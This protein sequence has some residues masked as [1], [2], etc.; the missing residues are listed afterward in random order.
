MS[1]FVVE[2]SSLDSSLS[3]PLPDEFPTREAAIA[4]LSAAT[5]AGTLTL[6]GEVFIADL[7]GAVPVLVMQAP[8]PATAT[9]KMADGVEESDS[10]TAEPDVAEE[11]VGN[12]DAPAADTAYASWEPLAE[13]EDG[14]ALLAEAL[15]RATTSLEDE[16]IVAPSSIELVP[17]ADET[18]EPE[19]SGGADED[20]SAAA[21]EVSE[22]ASV[23]MADGEAVPSTEW[24]W[25]N[26]ESYEVSETATGVSDDVDGESPTP[27]ESGD[28]VRE[29]AESAEPEGQDEDVVESAAEAGEPS[30]AAPDDGDELAEVL[31]DLGTSFDEPAAEVGPIITSAPGE[32]EDA[33][34]PRPVIL[35]DYADADGEVPI[36]VSEV[37]DPGVNAGDI[38][39]GYAAAGELD[40]GEYTCQDCVY[41]NTCPKVGEATPA[42]CGSFQWKSD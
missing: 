37:A 30:E 4:A 29:T 3:V 9:T 42:D 10:G 26:I 27:D 35:G 8:A 5:A 15:K 6:T 25:A 20:E 41:S 14:E 13:A 36:A 40:L 31:A 39:A 28:E 22:P 24:P 1:F 18:E 19:A 7:S 38:E 32:G 12:L 34:V 2:R 11:E 33:Y 16:G 21:S 23:L 17:T